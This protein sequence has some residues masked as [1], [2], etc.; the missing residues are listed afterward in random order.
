MTKEPEQPNPAQ[1]ADRQ[2][3]QTSMDEPLPQAPPASE[4]KQS[5]S[6]ETVEPD[7]LEQL[8]AELEKYR[9]IAMRTRADF[10]N[11]RK[12]SIREKEEALRYANLSLLEDLIP[13]VDN[14]ELGLS[15]AQETAD[16]ATILEGMSMVH[17]MFMDFFAS[18]GITPIH[19]EGQ[20]FNPNY[21]EAISQEHSATVEEGIVLRQARKGYQM[22]E[23]LLRAANVVVSQGS[24]PQKE[25]AETLDGEQ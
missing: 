9:D 21:H 15:A 2:K 23:R 12:R 3:E 1:E 5:Q 8:Q 19:S 16:T 20:P 22:G 10:E 7:P 14:F 13:V 6:V 18:Y 17:K 24:P 11:Y 4:N 25:S